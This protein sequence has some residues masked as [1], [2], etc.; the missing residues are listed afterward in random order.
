MGFDRFANG[1]FIIF[2]IVKVNVKLHYILKL[3]P[4]KKILIK[5]GNEKENF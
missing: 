3:L 5:R 2:S 1:N 4:E